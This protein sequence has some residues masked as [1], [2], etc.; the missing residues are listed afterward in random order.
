MLPT[1][2][3]FDI[4]S[5]VFIRKLNKLTHWHPQEGDNDLS[6]RAKLA[7]EKIF[8]DERKHSLWYV[9]TESEFYGVVASMTATA[10][11]KNRDIDFIWIEESELQEVGVV[12]ENV[13]NGNCLYVKS[14]H[15]DADINKS[16]FHDLCYNLMSKQREAYRCKKRQTTCILEYQ[17]QIGCKSTDIDA[18]SCECQSWR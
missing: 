14:L 8:P 1:L 6:L 2:A 17:R 5:G 13:P 9:S 16:I 12:F 7:S 4:R 10:T 11:P 3:D 18:E 15:F